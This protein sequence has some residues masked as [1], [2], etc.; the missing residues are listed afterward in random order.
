MA[1]LCEDAALDQYIRELAK[2]LKL[3]HRV[4]RCKLL[5]VGSRLA[6]SCAP[7]RPIHAPPTRTPLPRGHAPRLHVT[8]YAAHSD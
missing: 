3:A 1:G 6:A 7:H 4:A 8:P 5:Q 2:N